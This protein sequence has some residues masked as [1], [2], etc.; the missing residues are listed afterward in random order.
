MS[1]DISQLKMSRM[2]GGKIIAQ[3]PAC[4][5]C[6]GDTKGEHLFINADESWGCVLYPGDDG[7]AHRKDI[8]ALAGLNDSKSAQ[9]SKQWISLPAAPENAPFP[10]LHHYEHG[11]PSTQWV[12]KTDDGRIAS[13]VARFDTKDGKLVLPF[14]WCRDGDGNH[15]WRWKAPPAPRMIYGLPL[16]PGAVVLVEGEKCAEAVMA[17]GLSATTWQGGAGAVK[18]ADFSPLE[19]KDIFI[20]P[21]N[22]APG[23]RAKDAV[24]RLLSNIASRIRVIQIPADKPDGWDAADATVE[25]IK[26][27][28]DMAEVVLDH[29]ESEPINAYESNAGGIG[30]TTKD[31]D[32]D[33]TLRAADGVVE[34]S[35]GDKPPQPPARGLGQFYYTRSG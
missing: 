32:P 9:K 22:D 25:E 17:A 23:V 13:I 24:V 2:K 16:P 14:S 6:G 10:N 34:F 21:D 11:R 28:V 8:H 7:K 18:F 4:A 1:L 35:L 26:T 30:S 5:A 15:E 31:P 12:Y 33:D 27:L 19:G 20:W 29:T 3:C